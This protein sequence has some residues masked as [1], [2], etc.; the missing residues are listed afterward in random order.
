MYCTKIL[1]S[2]SPL[3]A[4]VATPWSG[5]RLGN[6][7]S[8]REDT[9]HYGWP[10]QPYNLIERGLKE[11][12]EK[13]N[14]RGRSNQN[15]ARKCRRTCAFATYVVLRYA[16]K[17]APRFEDGWRERCAVVNYPCL[18]HPHLLGCVG[19]LRGPL[20]QVRTAVVDGPRPTSG[21]Y[22]QTPDRSRV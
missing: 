11:D 2:G 21:C 17:N 14:T 18:T 7:F 6:Y 15:S 9:L 19:R 20:A 8:T 16:A 5:C 12:S 4:A 13:R 22:P 3:L 1:S 10:T